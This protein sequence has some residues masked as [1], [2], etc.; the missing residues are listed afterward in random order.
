[1]GF[2]PSQVDEMSFWE[3]SAAVDGWNKAHSDNKPK[4]P[5]AEEFDRVVSRM[6]H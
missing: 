4:P 5:S 1:M 6:V 2:T 3:I